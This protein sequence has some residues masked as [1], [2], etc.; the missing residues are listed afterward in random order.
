M[1]WKTRWGPSIDGSNTPY[2]TLITYKETH[3]ERDRSTRRTRRPGPARGAIRASARRPTAGEPENALTGQQFVV[4]SGTADITVPSQYSKLR[5][6]R[7]T[8]V[9]SLLAGTDA[10][11]RAGSRDA[12]LRVGRGRRQRLPAGRGVRPLLDDGQRGA[13]VHRLRQHASTSNGDRRP[14]TCTLYRAP[15]GAL[16]FGAGTVQWSWGLD[17]VNAWNVGLTEPSRNPPD[18]TCSRRRSTCSPTW[19][20]SPAR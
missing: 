19:A 2:R 14:T 6:W 11:A 20:P 12:R 1:F 8:A 10:D 16:V 13:G 5:L 4:N 9:A 18:P 7:N 17:N 3:F 15:S